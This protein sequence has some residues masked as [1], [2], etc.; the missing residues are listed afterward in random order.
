M[1]ELLALAIGLAL[2]IVVLAL[3]LRMLRA[4]ARDAKRPAEEYD[5]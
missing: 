5:A 4:G 3:A 1:I 2:W